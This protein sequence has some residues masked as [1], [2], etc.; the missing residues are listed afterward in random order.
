MPQAERLGTAWERLCNQGV[1]GSIPVRSTWYI[2]ALQWFLLLG[3]FLSWKSV[4][5][6]VAINVRRLALQQH[7]IRLRVNLQI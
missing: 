7:D 4:V 1:A 2:N 6:F 5:S 3:F